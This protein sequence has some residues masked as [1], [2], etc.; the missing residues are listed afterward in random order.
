MSLA[1]V[2]LAILSLPTQSKVEQVA[3][4][5]KR[6]EIQAEASARAKIIRAAYAEGES[7]KSIAKRFNLCVQRV[8]QILNHTR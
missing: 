1:D 6:S 2:T 5:R 8:F 7:A 4:R 3:P